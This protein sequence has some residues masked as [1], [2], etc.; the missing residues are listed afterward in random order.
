M[1]ADET[2]E[3]NVALKFLVPEQRVE[4]APADAEKLQLTGGDEV[5]V[6]SNGTAI[7][8]RVDI[9]ERIRPGSAFLIEGTAQNNANLLNGAT[10]VEIE[11]L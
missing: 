11:K 2:T 1:W 9:R 3:R 4:I 5:T 6:R 10:T 8:A 7:R